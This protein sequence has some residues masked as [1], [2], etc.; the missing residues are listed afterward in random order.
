MNRVLNNV[1]NFLA[2]DYFFL[3]SLVLFVIACGWVALASLYPMAFDEEFHY[4]LIQIYAT[5]WL[6]YGIEHTADMAQFGPATADASYLFHYLMSFPYRVLNGIGLPDVAI[7]IILRL[8]NLG[9]VVAG[10]VL[11]KRALLR[12]GAS[13]IITH[14]G[15]FMFLLIPTLT[16]LAA[17]INYDN[18]LFLV[19]AWCVLLVVTMTNGMLRDG[20]VLLRESVLL[21]V[22]VL[23]GM[24]IKYAFLPVA[25]AL[26]IWLVMV[27][28]FS[29]SKRRVGMS[30]IMH[31]I[32]KQFFTISTRTRVALAG[33]A[34][35]S[36]FFA[37]HYVVNALTYGSPIPSCEQVFTEQECTAY[38]PWNR[39]RN[40]VAD[41]SPNFVP[42][43]Y[44]EYMVTEWAPGMT[45]RLTFALA[46][47]TNGFQ[48]KEPLPVVII[49]FIILTII[50]SVCLVIQM[51]RRRVTWLTWL[52]L[53]MFFV[54]I[55]V[56]S[57]QLYG[58]Y[59]ETAKPVA[60]NGRYLIPLLPLVSVV[61]I[62]AIRGV[63]ARVPSTYLAAASAALLLLFIIGGAGAGTYIVQSEQHWF[64]PGFG[65]MSH[66]ILQTIVTALTLPMRF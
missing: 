56:L 11:F 20:K 47:K 21:A 31:D 49:G 41:R 53:L 46:G 52:T 4:G 42:L 3:A 34:V 54:Y 17:Q 25:A 23:I 60:I 1:K 35:L 65:Q 19:I 64:W 28:T 62:Q 15:L 9:F 57:F 39:N 33:L 10:V 38:G 7:V 5:S 32:R 36:L 50:S 30:A 43:S 12:A 44:P 37:S 6:P 2:S 14:V 40:Y 66:D 13:V 59:V 48:T 45:G 18:L 16:M 58:D 51:V 26:F 22:A 55:A 8:L 63:L 29:M 24:S 61:L 27:F